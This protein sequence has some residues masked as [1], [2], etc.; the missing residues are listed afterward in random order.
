[1]VKTF[2]SVSTSDNHFVFSM[3]F[4]G[5]CTFE[6]PSQNCEKRL[7]ASKCL[8]VRPSKCNNS[9]PTERIIMK[10]HICVFFEN[11]SRKFKF[12][13]NITQV[14][15]TLHEDHY[16][17][18]FNSRSGVLRTRN[19]SKKVCRE[20]QSTHYTFNNLFRKS[21]RL[22]HRVGKYRAEPHTLHMTIWRIYT[23]CWITK[24]T[25]KHWEYVI[26]TALPQQ[27]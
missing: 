27:Q 15:G 10:F 6:A 3:V 5:Q 18:F 26:F 8:F 24:S 17:I 1:M 4:L 19:P 7:L 12:H 14:T 16:I 23:A 22:W 11:L 20:N 2:K 9:A 13:S 25:N 21:C